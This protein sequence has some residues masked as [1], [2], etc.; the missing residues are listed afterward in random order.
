M[1]DTNKQTFRKYLISKANG[2][3]GSYL[4]QEESEQVIGI[5]EGYTI[6]RR[7]IILKLSKRDYSYEII[8]RK[9]GYYLILKNE[10]LFAAFKIHNFYS[11]VEIRT[12]NKTKIKLL[13]KNQY[14]TFSIIHEKNNFG[15]VNSQNWL[16]DVIGLVLTDQEYSELIL[17]AIIGLAYQINT[18]PTRFFKS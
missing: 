14:K 18:S 17:C 8:K 12:E 1:K 16:R 5:S 9:K 15:V 7:S 10:E 13:P 2:Y 11:Q 3:R 4:I 6:K